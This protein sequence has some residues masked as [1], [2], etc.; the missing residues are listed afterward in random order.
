MIRAGRGGGEVG[1]VA[2]G[3]TFQHLVF[4]CRTIPDKSWCLNTSRG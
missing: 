4:Y 1:G 2:G 3:G